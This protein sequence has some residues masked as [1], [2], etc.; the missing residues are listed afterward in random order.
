MVLLVL[1][2]NSAGLPGREDN[3]AGLEIG[4]D[5]LRR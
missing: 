5:S 3:W 2:R 1:R 4:K